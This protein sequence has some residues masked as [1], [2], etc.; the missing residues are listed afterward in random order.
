VNISA[1][2]LPQAAGGVG[3]DLVQAA[4]ELPEVA[5]RS[6][7]DAATGCGHHQ[8]PEPALGRGARPPPAVDLA[9]AIPHRQLAGAGEQS[10]GRIRLPV[11]EEL[12]PVERG[13]GLPKG[14]P[15]ASCTFIASR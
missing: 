10:G 7:L 5:C 11:A 14:A 13:L 1:K 9:E 4:G 15:T 12:R 2:A 6:S 3:V 8:A